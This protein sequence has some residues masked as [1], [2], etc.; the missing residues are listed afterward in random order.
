MATMDFTQEEMDELER[1]FSEFD[2]DGNGA[3]TVKELGEVME[4]LGLEP[5]DIELRDMVNEVDHDGNGTIEFLEFV[6]IMAMKIKD[7]EVEHE[8]KEAFRVFDEDGNGYI[9][10]ED[11]RHVMTHVGETM[12][13]EEV[14]DMILVADTEEDGQI[15]YEEFVKML[16]K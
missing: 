15:N 3:I 16:M 6:E 4:E 10:A 1:A 8:L 11:L 7:H 14:D 9:S 13:D 2:K 5:T 12:T